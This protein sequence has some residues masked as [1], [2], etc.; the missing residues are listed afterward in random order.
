MGKEDVPVVRDICHDDVLREG[1]S[2]KACPD[3]PAPDAS[4][5]V[6]DGVWPTGVHKGSLVAVREQER[7]DGGRIRSFGPTRCP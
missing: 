5:D 3:C 4:Q 2:P 1:E 7:P 6:L